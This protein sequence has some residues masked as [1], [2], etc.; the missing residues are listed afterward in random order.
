M[1]IPR[2]NKYF[3]I[4]KQKM[5]YVLLINNSSLDGVKC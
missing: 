4:N 1:F 3:E 5:D 2:F